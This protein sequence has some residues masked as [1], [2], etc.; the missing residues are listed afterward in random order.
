MA[1]IFATPA[2]FGWKVSSHWGDADEV[3]L[4]SRLPPDRFLRFLAHHLALIE[5]SIPSPWSPRFVRSLFRC[6]WHHFRQCPDLFHT[7]LAT[8]LLAL[9][10][11]QK[12][13]SRPVHWAY[14]RVDVS[15]RSW[16]IRERC[17]HYLFLHLFT[18][19]NNWTPSKTSAHVLIFN[20][21]LFPASTPPTK[22]SMHARLRNKEV[23]TT[24]SQHSS[25]FDATRRCM[26]PRCAICDMFS[27]TVSSF[28]HMYIIFT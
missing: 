25:F 20:G 28:A 27:C 26:P 5:T 3:A 4:I 23:Y 13:L 1:T 18:D 8:V 6:C 10:L 2:E 12:L 15:P 7:R 11:N 19:L 21:S 14:P 22:T 24:L 17:A 9:G 16:D